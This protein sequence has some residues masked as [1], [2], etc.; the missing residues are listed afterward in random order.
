MLKTLLVLSA[1]VEI[2]QCYVLYL[3]YLEAANLKIN[4]ISYNI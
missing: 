2:D 4:K 1:Y 3:L